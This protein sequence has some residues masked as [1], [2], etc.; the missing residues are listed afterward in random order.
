MLTFNEQLLNQFFIKKDV[1]FDKENFI[2]YY[3]TLF[4]SSQLFIS[5]LSSYNR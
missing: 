5:F 3:D 4:P 1:D 2:K